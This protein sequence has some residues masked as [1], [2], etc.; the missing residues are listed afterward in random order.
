MKPTVAS[1]SFSSASPVSPG[2]SPGDQLIFRT[3]CHGEVVVLAVRGQ[4]DAFTLPL[5]R[6]QVRHAA[7]AVAVAGLI[8][9]ATR[10]EF[11]S[12]RTLAAVADDAHRYRHDG[13]EVCLVTPDLRIARLA[14]CDPRTVH[15]QVRSTVV[16]AMTAIQLNRRTTSATGRRHTDRTP[17]IT[18][19]EPKSVPNGRAHHR[20]GQTVTFRGRPP[21]TATPSV[22]GTPRRARAD[23]NDG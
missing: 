12:L 7:E 20:A 18:P 22:P 4:A 10:L 2:R 9:D 5:W 14:A 16:S 3:R 23:D 21:D 8:I 19:D 15:L 11:L 13:V 1:S 17:R 6:Q